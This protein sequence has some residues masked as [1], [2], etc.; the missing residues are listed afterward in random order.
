MIVLFFA[1]KIR[2]SSK[3]PQII[4]KSDIKPVSEI[5]KQQEKLEIKV[6]SA[7]SIM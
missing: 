6:Q 1:R 2:S 7:S 5:Q 3:S 4:G